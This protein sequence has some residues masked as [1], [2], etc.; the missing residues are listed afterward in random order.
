[1]AFAKDGKYLMSG[2][3]ASSIKSRDFSDPREIQL[4]SSFLILSSPLKNYLGNIVKNTSN[5]P[6]NNPNIN[7]TEPFL[8][9]SSEQKFMIELLSFKY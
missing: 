7:L 1:M 8:P 5:D 2:S 6:S 3:T 9:P 4:D